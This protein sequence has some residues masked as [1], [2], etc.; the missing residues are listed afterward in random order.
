MFYS[1]VMQQ[2]S[3]YFLYVMNIF[4]I[5]HFAPFGAKGFLSQN[6]NHVVEFSLLK[7]K[8]F[9]MYLCKYVLSTYIVYTI[10]LYFI[11]E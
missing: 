9:C 4:I 7:N 10:Q 1:D 6:E 8:Y 5:H 11:Q 3:T 2:P